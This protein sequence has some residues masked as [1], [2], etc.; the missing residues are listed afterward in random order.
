MQ[1]S[2]TSGVTGT[3]VG[4]CLVVTVT[5]DLSQGVLEEMRR[6]TLE[7]IQRD[8]AKSAILE[9]SAVPF[10][11]THEFDQVR[12]VLRMAELLGA[13]AALVGLRPGIIAHLMTA[14]AEVRGVQGFLGLD[15]ALHA[16]GA[17]GGTGHA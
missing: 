10:L 15:D 5:Q 16:M 7:G 12:G 3:R 14:N 1:P 4:E 13:R 6:A 9:L 8:G 17:S 11:D 2:T